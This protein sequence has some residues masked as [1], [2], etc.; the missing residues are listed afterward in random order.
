MK[1]VFIIPGICLAL[2]AFIILIFSMAVP[3][4]NQNYVVK[5]CVDKYTAG[6]TIP[7]VV[8][9]VVE[10]YQ[11]R[12]IGRIAIKSYKMSRYYPDESFTEEEYHV[13]NSYDADGRVSSE[14][15]TTYQNG[16]VVETETISSITYD[17]SLGPYQGPQ[18]KELKGHSSVTL[19]QFRINIPPSSGVVVT[20]EDIIVANVMRGGVLGREIGRT[21]G[22][23]IFAEI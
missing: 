9:I 11:D 2:I 19:A 18:V 21:D 17:V 8:A 14:T 10:N 13:I 3:M 16:V 5:T 1:R 23:R 20:I 7:A 4:A 12:N 15:I 22:A 6:E